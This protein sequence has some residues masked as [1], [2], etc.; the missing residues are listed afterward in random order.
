MHHRLAASDVQETYHLPLLTPD[1]PEPSHHLHNTQSQ[2]YVVL[3][4]ET[5][6]Q[7]SGPPVSFAR[8]HP[9]ALPVSPRDSLHARHQSSD[10]AS[11]SQS[12]PFTSSTAYDAYAQ[13]L[14]PLDETPRRH[15]PL[16]SVQDPVYGIH[17]F[18]PEWHAQES[19]YNSQAGPSRRSSGNVG[20]MPN[21]DSRLAN[22]PPPGR[23]PQ[24]AVSDKGKVRKKQGPSV[25]R[26]EVGMA[27]Q[28]CRRRYVKL[29]SSLLSIA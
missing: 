17:R 2:P 24:A 6:F 7:P 29:D 15:S 9:T 3:K 27:C 12:H 14:Q 19:N 23:A 20:F 13:R 5:F 22:G 4:P 28:F 18:D 21:G 1:S 25:K 11:R 16:V 26:T 10:L 8:K